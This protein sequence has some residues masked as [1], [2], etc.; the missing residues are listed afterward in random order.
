MVGQVA[1]ALKLSLREA[2]SPFDRLLEVM[3]QLAH[4]VFCFDKMQQLDWGKAPKSDKH[5]IY[6]ILLKRLLISSLSNLSGSKSTPA[7]SSMS[8]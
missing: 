6:F 4:R 2:T 3:A 8:S 1:Q 7:Q 5:C